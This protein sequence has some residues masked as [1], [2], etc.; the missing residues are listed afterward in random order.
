MSPLP[1]CVAFIRTLPPHL[2]V[3]ATVNPRVISAFGPCVPFPLLLLVTSPPKGGVLSSL[4]LPQMR[5]FIH[6]LLRGILF[7]TSFSCLVCH[8][9]FFVLL[10][11][12]QEPF[13]LFQPDAVVGVG[14]VV[15]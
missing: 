5:L 11:D 14:D 2:A 7:V 4:A 10:L 6:T 12:S 15:T 8:L 3:A 9:C 1:V 13:N